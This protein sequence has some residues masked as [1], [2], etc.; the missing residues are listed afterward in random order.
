[1][2][3]VEHELIEPVQQFLIR[4]RKTDLKSEKVR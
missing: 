2:K 3:L 1:M 4:L